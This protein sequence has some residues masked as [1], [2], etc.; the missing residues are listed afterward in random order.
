MLQ[1][2]PDRVR[3]LPPVR[4]AG[5]SSSGL[6]RRLSLR[7]LRIRPAPGVG[8]CDACLLRDLT[9]TSACC[10]MIARPLQ[11]QSECSRLH[12]VGE[13]DADEHVGLAGCRPYITV[14][15]LGVP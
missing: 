4:P 2:T 6:D 14:L 3:S 9:G 11:P 13:A 8:G 5:L 10:A 7:R 15:V 1:T 12:C